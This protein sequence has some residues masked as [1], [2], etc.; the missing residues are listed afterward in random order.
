MLNQIPSDTKAFQGMA[1]N[2]VYQPGSDGFVTC[3]GCG[4]QNSFTR[5]QRLQSVQGIY[6]RGCGTVVY[7]DGTPMRSSAPPKV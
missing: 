7:R 4:Y 1:F 2:A 6:C 3:K 5:Q